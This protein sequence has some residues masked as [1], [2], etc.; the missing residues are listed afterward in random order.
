MGVC[1][2]CGESLTSGRVISALDQRFHVRC[3]VCAEPGCGKPFDGSFFV[4]DSR[5][6][7][8]EHAEQYAETETEEEEGEGGE[9]KGGQRNN[10]EDGT[11]EGQSV[12]D[13]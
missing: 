10:D 11:E 3:F 12:E 2:G 6:Y 5:P 8:Q 7:C 1:G 4:I 9:K 13:E